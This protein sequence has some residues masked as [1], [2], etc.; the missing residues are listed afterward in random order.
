MPSHAAYLGQAAELTCTG[1]L[2]LLQIGSTP[3]KSDWSL[4]LDTVCSTYFISKA[5]ILSLPSS[6]HDFFQVLGLP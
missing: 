3:K 1:T 4:D 2:L 6:L 5:Y